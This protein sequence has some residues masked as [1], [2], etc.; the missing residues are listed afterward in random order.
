MKTAKDVKRIVIAGAGTM[1]SS[2]GE[3][4][5]KYGY[6]VTLYDI[7]PSALEKAGN[8]IRLNQE[9]EVAEHVVTPEMI[10]LVEEVEAASISCSISWSAERSTFGSRYLPT[11]IMYSIPAIE[12][13]IPIQANSKKPKGSRPAEVIAPTAIIL[14][15]VP[16]IVMIPP[17]PQAN[18]RGIS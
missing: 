10:C 7:F 13:G 16:T 9:T 1:G 17:Q 6:D 8:L 18:A 11:N 15:G 2:M 5:A 14:G 4:F 12:T 3:T